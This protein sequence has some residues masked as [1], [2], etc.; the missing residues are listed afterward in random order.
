MKIAITEARNC[1]VQKIWEK[2]AETKVQIDSILYGIDSRHIIDCNK[3]KK[4]KPK[5]C[6]QRLPL[7]LNE[8]TA[9]EISCNAYCK[10]FILFC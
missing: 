2:I 5:I 4:I 1:N 9:F 6:W 3:N 10:F 8:D 7:L